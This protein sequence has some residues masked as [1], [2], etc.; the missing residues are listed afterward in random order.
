MSAGSRCCIAEM[1][2]ILGYREAGCLDWADC[3]DING[4]IE[5]VLGVHYHLLLNRRYDLGVDD[6]QDGLGMKSFPVIHNVDY[7]H[8]PTVVTPK[9]IM[10]AKAIM[11]WFNEKRPFVY[12]M[13]RNEDLNDSSWE[14]FNT[15]LETHEYP[16]ENFLIIK[17]TSYI[18]WYGKDITERRKMLNTF[19]DTLKT[20]FGSKLKLRSDYNPLKYS[21]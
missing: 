2:S 14:K 13:G 1:L 11:E 8:E 17:D 4:F 21:I 12:I 9:L 18:D 15:L 19:D 20:Y 16:R 5:A 6:I 7:I 3:K 10:R